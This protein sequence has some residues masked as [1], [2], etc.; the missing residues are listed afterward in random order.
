MASGLK[1]CHVVQKP[2][3]IF[4][5]SRS[6]DLTTTLLT[7]CQR[8]YKNFENHFLT[9]TRFGKPQF[10]FEAFD[11]NVPSAQDLQV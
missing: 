10:K 1:L 7:E 11:V 4:M 6:K 8:L 5:H 9:T 3:A 2:V